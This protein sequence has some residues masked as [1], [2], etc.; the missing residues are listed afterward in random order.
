M[1]AEKIT[2]FLDALGKEPKAAEAYKKIGEAATNEEKIALFLGLAKDM[3]FDLTEEEIKAYIK[4]RMA[5]TEKKAGAIEQVD[6]DELAKVAGGKKEHS[7]CL[8]TYRIGENCWVTDACDAV[9]Q[10]YPGNECGSTQVICQGQQGN[11][12]C[13]ILTLFGL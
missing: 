13:N 3:G 11:L 4:E 5:A 8:D 6:D 12:I 2:Q 10:G 7:E 9:L 1:A